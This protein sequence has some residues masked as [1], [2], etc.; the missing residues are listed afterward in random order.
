MMILRLC[1]LLFL[2]FFSLSFFCLQLRDFIDLHT[3]LWT[4]QDDFVFTGE[5]DR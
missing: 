3:C 1:L 5:L 4:I 2:F